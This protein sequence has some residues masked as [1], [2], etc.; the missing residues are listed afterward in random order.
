[1]AGVSGRNIFSALVAAIDNAFISSEEFNK[2]IELGLV[3]PCHK[4]G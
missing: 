2:V 3:P 4:Q 1:M